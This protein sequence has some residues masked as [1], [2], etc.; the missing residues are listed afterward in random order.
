M[1]YFISNHSFTVTMKTRLHAKV[2]FIACYLVNLI[3]DI[4]ISTTLYKK[5]HQILM[6][7]ISSVEQCCPSLLIASLQIRACLKTIKLVQYGYY[8]HNLQYVNNYG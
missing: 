3:P 4:Y 2:S 1:C 8:G 7:V 5:L 6:S